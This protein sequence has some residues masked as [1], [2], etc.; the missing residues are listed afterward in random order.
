MNIED[1]P[2]PS[3]FYGNVA[4]V[5]AARNLIPDFDK[6]WWGHSFLT[7]QPA[8]LANGTRADVVLTA[9][10]D[11]DRGTGYRGRTDSPIYRSIRRYY[12]LLIEMERYSSATEY[13]DRTRDGLRDDDYIVVP[14]PQCTVYGLKKFVNPTHHYVVAAASSQG[15]DS[16]FLLDQFSPVHLDRD[17]LVA[18]FSWFV[19]KYG[20]IPFYRISVDPS[21][22]GGVDTVDSTPLVAAHTEYV[23]T[24]RTLL[25]RYLQLV[26]SLDRDCLHL[27]PLG[28]VWMFTYCRY[29]EVRYIRAHRLEQFFELIPL[30]ERLALHWRDIWFRAR[31]NDI[32]RHSKVTSLE[33]DLGHAL[34]LE[35][36]YFSRLGQIIA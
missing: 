31:I 23:S 24:G 32:A 10:E 17:R 16:T 9:L 13:F 25:T 26:R 15:H 33:T 3:C 36:E 18:G 2:V 4:Y 21:W 27:A 7:E 1:N 12:P 29:S 14:F 11:V 19:E 35:D 20:D 8:V 28:F 34:D 30:L 6:V 5:T 22:E